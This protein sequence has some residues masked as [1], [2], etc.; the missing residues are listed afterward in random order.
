[1]MR[2][3]LLPSLL[4]AARHAKRHGEPNAQ[5][6]TMGSLFLAGDK[7]ALP[8]EKLAFAAVLSGEHTQHLSKPRALDVYDITGIADGIVQRITRKKA[9]LVRFDAPPKHLHPRGAARI[10]I[11]GVRV[12][13]LG[14]LHPEVLEHFELAHAMVIEFDAEALFACASKTP[15]FHAIP[16]F[17]AS[18][19]DLAVVVSDRLPAAEVEAI[20]RE[21][22]GPMAE[23][24]HVFDRFSGASIPKDHVSLAFHVIYRSADRTLKDEEVDKVHT[25]VVAAVSQKFG[26]AL[27]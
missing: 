2:T 3:S 9:T 24:V 26:A 11:D 12:G 1:V 17:P 10:E 7:G 19:R 16:K 5:V 20:I 25:S 4:G 22:A 27:R 15:Q 14:P 21:T 8:V 13:Q 23:S 18:P 6:F